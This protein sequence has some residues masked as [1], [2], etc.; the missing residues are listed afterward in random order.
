MR[1]REIE[2]EGQR[3]IEIGRGREGSGGQGGIVP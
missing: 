3:G 2:K 1:R